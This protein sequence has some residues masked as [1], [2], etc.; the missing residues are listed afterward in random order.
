[1]KVLVVGFGA[2]ATLVAGAGG[3]ILFKSWNGGRST[4]AQ[5]CIKVLRAHLVSPS[6]LKVTTVH[7]GT[8]SRGSGDDVVR[9]EY[10]ASN[11][12]NAT[13]RGTAIC[14]FRRV[15]RPPGEIKSL[16]HFRA[17]SVLLEGDDLVRVKRSVGISDSL[18]LEREQANLGAERLT[19]QAIKINNCVNS[20]KRLRDGERNCQLCSVPAWTI[21]REKV[22]SSQTFLLWVRISLSKVERRHFLSNLR[23]FDH[24][25]VILC[26]VP[27]SVQRRE[28]C[29]D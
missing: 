6:S 25:R 21:L 2:I 1:M 22:L 4:E 15:S 28:D 29:R 3:Y 8:S 16:A 20:A 14:S 12:F 10:D 11:A 13:L 24:C 18:D 7:D 19:H 5:D 26:Y 9:I 27:R 23:F 17:A